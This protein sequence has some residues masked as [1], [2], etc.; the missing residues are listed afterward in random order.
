MRG[1]EDEKE[2]RGHGLRGG[3]EMR[4]SKRCEK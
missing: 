3:E 1:K 2:R 4:S